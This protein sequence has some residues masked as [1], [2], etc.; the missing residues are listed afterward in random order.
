MVL[1]GDVLKNET[2]HTW[3][4]LPDGYFNDLDTGMLFCCRDDGDIKKPIVLPTRHPFALFM[5]ANE[6][7]C[8]EVRGQIIRYSYFLKCTK[9]FTRI[10][11]G[12]LKKSFNK[13]Y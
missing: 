2:N 11:F 7:D 5:A 13:R 10:R 3:G 1:M 4:T 12:V 9:S 6:S 8:Q